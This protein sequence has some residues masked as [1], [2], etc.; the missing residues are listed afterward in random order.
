MTGYTAAE[1]RALPS[2]FD[3]VP[4]AER[5]EIQ[6]GLTARFMSGE[7]VMHVDSALVTKDGRR[8]DIEASIIRVTEDGAARLVT[9]VRD[10]TD[11]RR[12]QEAQR[13][14]EAKSRLMAMMNHEVRTPLN[15]ILG[16]THLLTEERSGVLNEK[17]RR[18]V[19]NI[20][21]SGD[22]LLALV[23]DSLDLAKLDAG[24]VA[25]KLEN[26]R[27]Q[28]V[29]EQAADQMRPLAEAR[30]LSLSVQDAGPADA[31][32]DSRQLGQVLLNLL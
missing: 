1:L 14:S 4:A 19:N 16:F 24:R 9:I 12:A 28:A 15:S 13:D 6:R 30:G 17:Q 7:P 22:H 2:V 31:H 8:R 23:N 26:V 25:V 27:V 21:V 29:M 3:L 32:A 20:Q 11:Q 5:E 10:V 18:Y